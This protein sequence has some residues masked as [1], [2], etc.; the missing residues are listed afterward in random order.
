[1]TIYLLL[2]NQNV[3]FWYIWTVLIILNLLFWLSDGPWGFM[4]VSDWATLGCQYEPMWILIC[5]IIR[6]ALEI[7]FWRIILKHVC[8]LCF[9]VS[10]ALSRV[11][12]D[13][14]FMGL[15]W[16]YKGDR[17]T[18]IFVS[19]IQ[20]EC[21]ICL[22]LFICFVRSDWFRIVYWN[23]I[24]VLKLIHLLFG[25][26]SFLSLCHKFYWVSGLMIP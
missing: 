8:R 4:W 7:G 13:K 25:T 10:V 1:M 14:D 22:L 11:W 17:P 2:V 15:Y 19:A 18:K 16:R 3:L 20:L 9:T 5:G 21:D 12:R 24:L 26:P 23:Q 6:M